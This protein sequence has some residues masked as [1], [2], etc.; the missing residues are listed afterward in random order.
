MWA[1]Q[2]KASVLGSCMKHLAAKKIIVSP[3]TYVSQM[4]NRPMQQVKE[5]CTECGNYQS[6][7]SVTLI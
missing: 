2:W 5:Y 7:I 3:P 6:F 1:L 4:L